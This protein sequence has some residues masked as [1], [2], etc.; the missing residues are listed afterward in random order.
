MQTL[1]ARSVLVNPGKR[2]KGWVLF[3]AA[4]VGYVAVAATVIASDTPSGAIS[5]LSIEKLK[6]L[7]RRP[8]A[9]PYPKENP[10]SPA[11]AKLGKILFFETRLSRSGVS[12]CTTCH[13]P[14]L[15]WTD[16]NAKGVGDHHQ[17]LPRKDPTLLNLAWDELFFWDGRADSLEH[18]TA[19]PIEAPG[20]LNMKLSDA[21]VRLKAI[22]EYQPLFAA[23]F[24][25]EK[26]PITGDNITRAIATYVRTIVS[27][28]APFDRW[29]SGD[30]RAISPAAKR[31]FVLF[32]GKANCAACHS[33]WKFSDGSFHD[34]G[35]KDDDIG[36]G[37]YVSL[38]IM[39]HAFKTVGLRNIDR[40]APYMHNGSMTTLREVIDH[41]DHGFAQRDSL[42][43]E[44]KPLHLSEQEKV[45]LLEFLKTLT[46]ND[47]PVSMPDLPK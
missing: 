25:G 8:S 15:S 22:P 27:G 41:Y 21:V 38:P 9:I 24:P 45:D 16:G 33:G 39:Q 18:Q 46:S 30:E 10:Y 42:A 35:I 6:E 44:I 14:G 1:N 32:N 17:L 23:A 7:Y 20:E 5:S 34:I 13:N 47:A 11:K 28:T 37:K 31:G 4:T 12:N 40:R 2:Y 43:S 3:L 29:V 19:G 26:D 36:R